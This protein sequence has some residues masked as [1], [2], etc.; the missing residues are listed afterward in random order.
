LLVVFTIQTQYFLANETT[1]VPLWAHFAAYSPR[2]YG[3]VISSAT[4]YGTDRN[5]WVSVYYMDVALPLSNYEFP[6][7]GSRSRRPQEVDS[8]RRG[9]RVRQVR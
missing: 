4:G 9:R 5:R 7:N 3:F 1:G 6:P 8:Q 2:R